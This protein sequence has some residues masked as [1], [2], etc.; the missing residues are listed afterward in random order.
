MVC[1]SLL[2][3]KSLVRKES[4]FLGGD[5]CWYYLLQLS[6]ASGVPPALRNAAWIPAGGSE[7]PALSTAALPQSSKDY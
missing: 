3:E 1:F 7:L 4:G 5:F 2:M 6:R